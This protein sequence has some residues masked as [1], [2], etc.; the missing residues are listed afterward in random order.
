MGNCTPSPSQNKPR[1]SPP[2]LSLITITK[3]N[4]EISPNFPVWKFCGKAQFP[5]SFRRIAGHS[6][7]P[8][9]APF[10]K[11]SAPGKR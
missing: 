9:T 2:R 11:M 8:E 4:T 5:Q 1:K 6:F 3:Y 7:T 10:N